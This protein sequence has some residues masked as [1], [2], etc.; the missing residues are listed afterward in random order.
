MRAK[1]RG[2]EGRGMRVRG[3]KCGRR[4]EGGEGRE[5]E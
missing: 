2:G 5:E 4:I 3:G 1:E